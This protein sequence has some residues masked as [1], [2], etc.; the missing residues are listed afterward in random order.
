MPS[1]FNK[2][3]YL[4]PKF[5]PGAYHFLVRSL[6]N[7]L[8]FD[9]SD[10]AKYRHHVLVFFYT[11]GFKAAKDAF[12][13][14]KSTLY[15]WKKAYEASGKR[16][17]SLVPCSTRPHNTRVMTTDPRLVEFIKALREEYGNVGKEKI[18]LFL[19]EYCSS[20]NIPTLGLTTIGKVIKRK[21]YFFQKNTKLKVRRK[22]LLYPRVRHAPKESAPGYLEMDSVIL[23]VLGRRYYFV[24]C[25][26]VVTKYASC[27]L[28]PSLSGKHTK[29]VYAH[30]SAS[31]PHLV[32]AVQTDNGS[33]FLG[34]FDQHLQ[35][36]G[37]KHEFIYPKSP[38]VNGV[39]ERFNRTIQEEF[40]QRFDH[41]LETPELFREKMESYLTYYNTKRPHHSL[42]LQTPHQ[43]MKNYMQSPKGM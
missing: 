40:I 43:F 37:V 17:T 23:Y 2:Q 20:V 39:V 1:D 5:S 26:D 21:R 4:L 16:L 15:D 28:V 30:F 36:T 12:G 38:K 6:T 34:E 22:K 33:E 32:R 11:H 9:S 3:V 10:I 19:D 29:S 24:T 13:V 41:L 25:V 18:K 27:S 31:Y 42:H 14:K 35:E 7:S 8:T